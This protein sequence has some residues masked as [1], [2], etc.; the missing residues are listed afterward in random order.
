MG[1]F[2]CQQI[3]SPSALSQIGLFSNSSMLG[4]YLESP[5]KELLECSSFARLEIKQSQQLSSLKNICQNTESVV[6]LDESQNKDTYK[7]SLDAKMKILREKISQME[8][9]SSSATKI[10]PDFLSDNT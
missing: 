7:D 3:L 10:F 2:S 5:N 8:D 6:S 1:T 4:V 9:S